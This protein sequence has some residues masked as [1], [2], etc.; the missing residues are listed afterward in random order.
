[1]R[2]FSFLC[3][4]NIVHIVVN[5]LVN[6][7]FYCLLFILKEG[8]LLNKLI[9]VKY[10]VGISLFAVKKVKFVKN[11]SLKYSSLQVVLVPLSIF[12]SII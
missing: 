1:M 10:Y 9:D 2:G 12:I 8:K 7:S 11:V 4:V 3:N 6:I 5:N